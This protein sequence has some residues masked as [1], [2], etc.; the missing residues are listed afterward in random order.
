M[1]RIFR[2]H[3]AI[4]GAAA[5]VLI[6]AWLFTQ[7]EPRLQNEL[8]MDLIPMESPPYYGREVELTGVPIEEQLAPQ[9]ML[10]RDYERGTDRPIT[11]C[12]VYNYAR[13]SRSFHDPWICY[14]AQ[15]Y[16][17]EE[18]PSREMT[19]D[20]QDVTAHLLVAE[21]NTIDYLVVYWYMSGDKP[22]DER[23]GRKG[24]FLWT[25]VQSRLNRDLGVSS[26]I[27]ASIPITSTTEAAYQQIAEFLEAYYPSI[28]ALPAD[29]HQEPMP[30]RRLWAQGMPGQAAVVALLL[31]PALF[32][33]ASLL[34]VLQPERK[35]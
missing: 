18:L 21:K 31:L 35:R 22:L 11:L 5:F 28:R 30:A 14:P 16:A 20:G 25:T 29:V 2:N 1:N 10:F 32:A 24:D 34:S 26:M 3:G 12:L 7:P 4:L 15:G 6:C 8:D 27:R 19:L 23:G 13:R 33:G 9:A 17:L